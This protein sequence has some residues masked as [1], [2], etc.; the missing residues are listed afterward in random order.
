MIKDLYEIIT[1]MKQKY[2][3]D[4]SIY[5]QAFLRKSIENRCSANDINSTVEY[6]SCLEKYG[7]E[8]DD[9]YSTLNINYSQ[10]FRDPMTF[11]LLEQNIFPSIVSHKL[12]GEIRIWSAGC[13][14]GQEAYSLAIL[15]SDIAD[16]SG[17]EL[18]LRI[19]ATDISEESLAVGRAGVYDQSLVQNVKMKHLNKY[20]I[21]NGKT[22]SIIPQ[23]KQHIEFSTY[24]LLDQLTANPP[25]SIYGDFDIVMCSNVLIYYKPDLQISIIKK[26]QKA[27]S[28]IGY[29][30]T[31]EAE[32]TLLKNVTKMQIITPHTAVFK[33]NIGG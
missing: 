8:A 4:I 14:N 1:I 28:S 2:G 16:N 20:F 7:K 12:K 19:F 17:K 33:N 5:D 30:V 25:G 22:Y 27:T 18:R 31:G 13:S 26:L 10:F 23:L 3:K 24:D 6:C 32:K 29:L 15:L 11:A 21:K 9:F